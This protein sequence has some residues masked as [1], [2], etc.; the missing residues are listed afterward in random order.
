MNTYRAE[1]FAKCPHNGIHVH[2]RLSI[3][4]R[5]VIQVEKIA[6]AVHT[7]GGGLHEE[8]ADWLQG[9][10]GGTQTLV[11]EHHG[12]TIETERP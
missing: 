12:I 6:E 8:I 11:A 1:F 3:A 7:I 5:D 2:Y 9:K 10:F 4:T